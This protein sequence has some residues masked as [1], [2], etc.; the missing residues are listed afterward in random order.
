MNSIVHAPIAA[1]YVQERMAQATSER[2]AREVQAAAP[3]TSRLQG[4]RRQFSRRT[5]AEAGAPL[6][7]PAH[8]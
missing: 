3:R 8:R 7:V 2:R 1:S 4:L 6:G 5:R